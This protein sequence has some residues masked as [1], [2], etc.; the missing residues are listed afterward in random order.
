MYWSDKSL[1]IY[2]RPKYLLTNNKNINNSDLSFGLNLYIN[3]INLLTKE[4]ADRHNHECDK[5]V[6]I[7]HVFQKTTT[8]KPK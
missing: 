1:I 3:L 2:F 7:I 4:I 6:E 8:T 5:S